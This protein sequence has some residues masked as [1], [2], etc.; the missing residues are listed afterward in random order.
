MGDCEI[1]LKSL[2]VADTNYPLLCPESCGFNM[3]Q[4]CVEHLVKTSVGSGRGSSNSQSSYRLLCPRCKGNVTYT[5]Q[6]TL[7]LREAQEMQELRGLS[8]SQ[9]NGAELRQKHAISAEDIQEAKLRLDKYMIDIKNGNELKDL[10]RKKPSESMD[11]LVDNTLFFGLSGLMSHAEKA[12]VTEL[13]TSGNVN[14]LAQAAQILSEIGRA[15]NKGQLV[16][17]DLSKSKSNEMENASDA[18]KRALATGMTKEERDRSDRLAQHRRLYPLPDRM[19]R[20]VILKA[21]F[22]VFAK[23]GKVLKFIDDGWD[24]SVA[25]A[26]SRVSLSETTWSEEDS[27]EL[28]SDDE[29]EVDDFVNRNVQKYKNRVLIKGARRQAKK[30]GILKGDVVSHINGDEFK[31]TADDL[32]QLIDK[33][34]RSGNKNYTFSLTLNAEQSTAAALKLRAMVNDVSSSNSTNFV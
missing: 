18:E 20:Y 15:V 29:G 13:M 3:C 6:D 1:C 27:Y 2:S 8:D 30:V 24:G 7:L 25:D 16:V 21:D 5:I 4:K 11:L 14:K 9:L 34:Y 22:D 10:V 33:F 26:F 31:G 12:Y 23:H 28:D 19:P 32:K 17:P